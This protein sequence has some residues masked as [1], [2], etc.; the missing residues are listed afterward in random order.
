M[1]RQKLSDEGSHLQDLHQQ[2]EGFLPG[3]CH[4]CDQLKGDHSEGRQAYLQQPHGG[5]ESLGGGEGEH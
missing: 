4:Q 1:D 5:E 2:A 3:P